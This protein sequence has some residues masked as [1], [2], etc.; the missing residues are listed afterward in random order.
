MMGVFF[1]KRRT[2]RTIFISSYLLY[3]VLNSL[4]YLLFGMAIVNLIT[5]LFAYSIISLNYESSKLKR[6][7]AV[8]CSYAYIVA[9]EVIVSVALTSQQPALYEVFDMNIHGYLAIGLI[10]YFASTLLR[11]F[12]NI[13]IGRIS[14]PMVLV[15]IIAIPSVSVISLAIVMT[16]LQQVHALIVMSIIFGINILVFYLHDTLSVTYQSK[17]ESTL[18]AQEKEYYYAQCQLMQ[19]S[20]AQVKSIRHDMKMHLATATGFIEN[21]NVQEAEGYLKKLLGNISASEVYSDTGNIALDSIINFKLKNAVEDNVKLEISI[22]A[23]P[24]LDV[25]AVDIVTILGNL[26]DNALDA[27]A[28]VEDKVIRLNV[29]HVKGNLFIK[30]ENTFDGELKYLSEKSG[31]GEMPATRKEGSEHGHGLANIR[32]SVEKY[33]GD[34]GIAHDGGVFSVSVL[35]YL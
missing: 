8:V 19:E 20:V 9:I 28:K 22:L 18:H 3:F 11:K 15:A 12:K 1:E 13:R 17:L 35:L 26:L 25:E 31:A 4:A 33:S 16:N 34:L 6:V 29:E 5:S 2:N 10:A 24:V 7:V 32:R 30:V 27:V 23:P 21:D 14:S